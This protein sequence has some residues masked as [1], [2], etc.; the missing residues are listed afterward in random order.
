MIEINGR[1]RPGLIYDLARAIGRLNL[2]I[3]SAQIATS[4]AHAVDVFYVKDTFGLK[5]TS[6]ARIK[7][8]ETEL[9]AASPDP[10]VSSEPKSGT[11][12]KKAA[13]W[14]F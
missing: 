14:A 9:R 7:K 8:I 5:V 13:A 11:K 1:D 6:P 2:S 3:A 4:G 10:K 12:T